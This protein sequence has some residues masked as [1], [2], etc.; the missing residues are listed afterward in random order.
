[1]YFLLTG[2]IGVNPIRLLS[3]SAQPGR[4]P[5]YYHQRRALGHCG[6]PVGLSHLHARAEFAAFLREPHGQGQD[7]HQKADPDQTDRP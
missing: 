7:E 1:M 3:W 2:A 4:V 5:S 6:E